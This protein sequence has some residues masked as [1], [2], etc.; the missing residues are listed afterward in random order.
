MYSELSKNTELFDRLLAVNSSFDLVRRDIVVCEKS[1]AFY[2]VDG[3]IK[4]ETMQKVLDVF[5]KL[6]SFSPVS[7]G[8][9]KSF[10]DTY[11][12]YVEV[13][14]CLNDGDVVTGVLSGMA[15][16]F[17]DGLYGA[18]MIDARTYPA[19][20]VTEPEND[21]ILRGPR[22]GF[23]ET[24]VFN[25]ALIRRHI[26]DSSLTMEIKTVG[27]VSKTD[28]VLCY[29]KGRADDA[30]LARLRELIDGI[31]AGALTLS[32]ES[33]AECL[34]RRKWYNP[35]PKIR[36]T[37]RPDTAAAHILEGKIVVICDNSPSVMILP[38]SFFDFLQEADDYYLPPLTGTYLRFIVLCYKEVRL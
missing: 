3:L 15:A 13:D 26:R 11:I 8:D 27:K 37:E 33:L 20:S 10:Y 38:T 1:C 18:T 7:Y 19:R 30:Y 36:Y 14:E 17:V 12:A 22:V 4:D 24:L 28:V 29:M 9:I 5:M 2:F 32:S 34:I 25:T 6:K 31:D 35:F 23:V 21:K 16:M